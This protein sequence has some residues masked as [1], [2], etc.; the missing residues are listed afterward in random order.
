MRLP[1]PILDD[2]SYEQLRDELLRRAAVYT[3]EWTGRNDPSS[4]RRMRRA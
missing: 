1:I 4:L 2:R 3:P